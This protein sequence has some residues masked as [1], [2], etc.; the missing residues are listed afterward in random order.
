MSAPH[1]K[2]IESAKEE[3]NAHYSQTAWSKNDG[4]M[5]FHIQILLLSC[6]LASMGWTVRKWDADLWWHN[7]IRQSEVCG[8]EK[9][10]ANG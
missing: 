5:P 10:G 6:L 4:G 3:A 9:E 1:G 2:H 8:G 7:R